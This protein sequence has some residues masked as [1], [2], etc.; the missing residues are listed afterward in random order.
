MAMTEASPQVGPSLSPPRAVDNP[1][2]IMVWSP[3]MVLRRSAATAACPCCPTSL[4]QRIV[5]AGSA[6]I[7]LFSLG[8]GDVAQLPTQSRGHASEIGAARLRRARQTGPMAGGARVILLVAPGS[9][10]STDHAAVA[11]LRRAP[12]RRPT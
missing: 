11:A 5:Y 7:D 6:S 4:V 1:G 9:L 3:A 2:S 10:D 12:S 8:H